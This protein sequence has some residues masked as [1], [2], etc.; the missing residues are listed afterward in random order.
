[1]RPLAISLLSVACLAGCAS[2]DSVGIAVPPPGTAYRAQAS[3]SFDDLARHSLAEGD[4]VHA[5]GAIEQA[6]RI[7]PFDPVA[8][9]NLAVAKT[10]QGQFHEG[11]ELLQ[12]AAQLAPGN[13]EIAANLSRLRVWNQNYAMIGAPGAPATQPGLQNLPPEPPMLWSPTASAR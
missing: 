1:M 4:P 10:E 5:Q 3:N 2:T 9:N 6:L 11:M 7:N 13:A 12:R 8:L